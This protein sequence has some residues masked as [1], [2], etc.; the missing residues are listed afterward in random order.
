MKYYTLTMFSKICGVA[1][2]TFKKYEHIGEYNFPKFDKKTKE[3]KF[4]SEDT[5]L[6]YKKSRESIK[7]IDRTELIELVKKQHTVKEIAKEMGYSYFEISGYMRRNKIISKSKANQKVKNY[8]DQINDRINP[9]M[10]SLAM[11]L[12]TVGVAS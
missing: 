8:R 12:M 11:K 9:K 2:G 5:V 7:E 6:K 1:R 10:Y 3:T 4:W